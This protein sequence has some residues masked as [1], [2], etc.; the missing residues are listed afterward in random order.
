MSWKFVYIELKEVP[1]STIQPQ[2]VAS[3][4]GDASEPTGLS[5]RIT[6]WMTEVSMDWALR[7]PTWMSWVAET[8]G[9]AGIVFVHAVLWPIFMVEDLVLAKRQHGWLRMLGLAL[10]FGL[11]ILLGTQVV[12]FIPMGIGGWTWTLILGVAYVII[13]A[14]MVV[15]DDNQYWWKLIGTLMGVSWFFL[16]FSAANMYLFR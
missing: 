13:A 6:N 15:V 14:L 9:G 16:A 1:L 8:F 12:H 10:C 3:P 2:T 4:T 11:A 7:L 5:A